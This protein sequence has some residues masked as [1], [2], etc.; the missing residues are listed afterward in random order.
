[1][2][3]GNPPRTSLSS[4]SSL[5]R[6]VTKAAGLVGVLLV[7]SR[8]SGFIRNAAI[9]A[10]FGQGQAANMYSAAFLGPDAIYNILIGGAVSSAFIPVLSRY[11]TAGKDEDAW[12]VVSTAVNITFLG[13]TSLVAVGILTASWWVRW[14]VP[15]FS[16]AD[17]SYT[18][19]L[20]H[21]TLGSILFNSLCGVLFG[22]QSSRFNF[23]ATGTGPILFNLVTIATGVLLAG[24]MGIASFALGTLL[25]SIVNFLTQVAGTISLSPRYNFRLE[26]RHPGVRRVVRLMV[27]IM[28]SGAASQIAL[29][30]NQS[31]L[32]SFEPPGVINALVLSSRLM[33]L[34]VSLGTMVG[35]ALLPALSGQ[36]GANKTEDFRRFLGASLRAVVFLAIPASLGL[37]L[38]A[39]PAVAILFQHGNFTAHDTLV[40]STS[41]VYYTIGIVAYSSL[42]I[43]YRAYYALEDTLTPFKLAMAY[44]LFSVLL[45]LGLIHLLGYRGLALAYSLSGFFNLALLFLSLRHRLGGIGGYPLARTAVRSLIASVGGGAVILL[46]E[47]IAGSI[48][49]PALLLEGGQVAAGLLLGGGIFLALGWLLG[50]EEVGILLDFFLER[51]RR[52]P[53]H[54]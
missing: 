47:A 4:N 54:P 35:V 13:M 41:L 22:V 34:P 24:K 26:L 37:A 27:P 33:L 8:I 16:P 6:V 45:S 48:H 39:K 32:A 10:I 52:K 14:L 3:Q 50:A 51:F 28:I 5:G 46:V 12:K 36:A 29:V 40:T 11:F 1:M 19:Y 23:W 49:A 18:A 30:L 43:V 42:E 21:L 53:A 2:S 7:F 9:A 20:T 38:L 44:L 31:F 17:Q 15:G 25:G